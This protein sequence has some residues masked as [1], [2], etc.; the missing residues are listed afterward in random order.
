[1]S[2]GFFQS[3]FF[4]LLALAVL[5][6]FAVSIARIAPQRT[7]INGRLRNLERKITETEKSNRNLT[8]LLGYFK[9]RAYL[10]RESKLKLNVRRPDE[11]VIF[12]YEDEKDNG[13]NGENKKGFSGLEGMT[14]F[15]KWLKYLFQ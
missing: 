7:M 8:R 6:F 9:S 15:E 10:E 1:M 14:N 5:F 3:K 4:T 11:N 13:A 2:R 12:I